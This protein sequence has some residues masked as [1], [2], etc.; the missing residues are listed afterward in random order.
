MVVPGFG[1]SVSMQ[2]LLMEN[3]I[4]GAP[5]R[6]VADLDIGPGVMAAEVRVEL[7]KYDVPT[8]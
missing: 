3:K 2:Q 7:C 1:D 6:C 5:I 8:I 4:D